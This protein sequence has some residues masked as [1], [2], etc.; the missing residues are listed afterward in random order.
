MTP[1]AASSVSARE[2]TCMS[3]REKT[4]CSYYMVAVTARDAWRIM[5]ALQIAPADFLRYW[6]RECEAPGRFLLKPEGPFSELVLAKRPMPEP[7]LS[8]CVF[9]LRTS[10]G[11]GLCGLGDLRP[12]RCQSHPVFLQGELIRLVNDSEGCVRTWSYGDLDLERERPLLMRLAAD[13]Q[14][15]HA[16]VADWNRRVS[17]ERRERA[18]DEFCAYLVNRC[19][20]EETAA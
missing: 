13:E 20:E 10:D 9:L 1:R 14:E 7:L 2:A 15:H 3:C 5:R 19:A 18:F 6:E 12:G 11:H 8:P 17:N 16:M 4:C